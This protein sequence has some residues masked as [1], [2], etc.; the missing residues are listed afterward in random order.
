MWDL[1]W[2]SLADAGYEVV[3]CDFR[4]FGETPAETGP[5]SDADDVLEL[6]DTLGIDR[7]TLIGSSYG[8]KVALELAGRRPERAVAL[9]L[10]CAGQPGRPPGP[11]LMAFGRKEDALLEAG[12][13]EAAVELNVST[14]LGPDADDETRE[15]VRR[16][17]RHAFEVQLAAEKEFADAVPAEGSADDEETP[18]AGEAGAG[19]AQPAEPDLSRI[20]APCLA[21]S[22]A[23]DVE[24]F[25]QIAAGLPAL[26]PGARH[27]ELDWAQHLPSLERPA[28]VTRLITGFL[29]GITEN[30]SR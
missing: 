2:Q 3:R 1:Q 4:G 13:L 26:I 5:Y 24:D 22:G 29:A 20:D 7:A 28:E 8:G 15:A 21:V 18:G 12:D 19:P 25:R 23:H 6:L 30:V 27:V 9:M 10:L 16:M 14:W 17:Q 11:R